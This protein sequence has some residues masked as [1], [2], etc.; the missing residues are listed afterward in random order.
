MKRL[1]FVVLFLPTALV[2]SVYWP[3][4]TGPLG[5]FVSNDKAPS[6]FSVSQ[7]EAVHWRVK[8][9]STGQGT[10]VVTGG[11]VFVTSHDEITEDS[12]VGSTILG[13]CFDANTGKELW[14]RKIGGTRETDLS[15]LV[16]DNTAA[17][18]VTDG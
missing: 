13:M 8:L 15:S 17:S 14:R 12:Q 11:R 16:S 7:N 2:W 10:P 1:F 18:A 9:P 6:A 4:A 5:N 3:Q